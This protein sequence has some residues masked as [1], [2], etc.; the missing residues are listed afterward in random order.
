MP[1]DLFNK[2]IDEYIK[3]PAHLAQLT[4][5]NTVK[6]YIAASKIDEK[7]VGEFF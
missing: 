4:T 3:N 7:G 5:N 2:K 1:F 6:L